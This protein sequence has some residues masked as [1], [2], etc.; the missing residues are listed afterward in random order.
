MCPFKVPNMNYILIK[1][2]FEYFSITF[3]YSNDLYAFQFHVCLSASVYVCVCVWWMYLHLHVYVY[4]HIYTSVYIHVC[5]VVLWTGRR[6]YSSYIS[7]IFRS[8]PENFPFTFGMSHMRSYLLLNSYPPNVA[9]LVLVVVVVMV[10]NAYA[11]SKY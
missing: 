7:Y 8:D 4:I 5:M 2:Y 11:R 1:L 9:P 3:Q 6:T 10:T